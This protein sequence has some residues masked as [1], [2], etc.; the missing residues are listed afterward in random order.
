MTGDSLV[1]D[2]KPASNTHTLTHTHTHLDDKKNIHSYLRSPITALTALFLAWKAILFAIVVNCPG[3]G[4]DTSTS[5]LTLLIT[6]DLPL[7]SIWKFVRWDAIYFVRVAE[8]GYLF[9]QEWAWGY[10][11]TRLLKQISTGWYTYIQT[12]MR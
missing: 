1:E 9:E 6:N 11:Y 2:N 3:L 4:Y 10:G 5:S 8:R 12:Y 7:A